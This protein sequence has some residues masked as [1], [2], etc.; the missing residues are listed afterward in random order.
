MELVFNKE[1]LLRAMQMLQ[2]VAAGRNTLRYSRM[3]SSVHRMDRL[4]FR[5]LTLSRD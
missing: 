5:Q 2:G 1:E 3:F 4:R